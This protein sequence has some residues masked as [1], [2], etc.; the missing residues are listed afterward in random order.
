MR[1]ISHIIPII[2]IADNNSPNLRDIRRGT[3]EKPAILDHRAISF[4][5][6]YVDV[7][8]A[9]SKCCIGTLAILA[10]ATVLRTSPCICEYCAG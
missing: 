8:Y 6:E 3:I 4:L 10:G 1:T 2:P 5:K 7:P 9:L